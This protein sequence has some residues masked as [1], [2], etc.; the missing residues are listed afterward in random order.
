MLLIND[1][2]AIGSAVGYLL[3]GAHVYGPNFLP[4]GTLEIGSGDISP[5][6]IYGEVTGDDIAEILRLISQQANNAPD[7]TTIILGGCVIR[8]ITAQLDVMFAANPNIRKIEFRWVNFS[9]QN[10]GTLAFIL[11]KYPNLQQVS[12][13]D[14]RFKIADLKKLS[15]LLRDSR[16][17]KVSFFRSNFT[18][19]A[20]R[21]LATVAFMQRATPWLEFLVDENNKVLDLKSICMLTLAMNFSLSHSFSGNYI[22]WHSRKIKKLLEKTAAD[23]N[24][25][26]DWNKLIAQLKWSRLAVRGDQVA[27]E[28][29]SVKQRLIAP[30]FRSRKQH[31]KPQ[32]DQR[33]GTVVVS[34]ELPRELVRHMLSFLPPVIP[35]PRR[36]FLPTSDVIAKVKQAYIKPSRSW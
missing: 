29:K 21:I 32:S 34:P 14:V 13:S 31:Q 33:S 16:L 6:P 23:Y 8:D 26:R 36:D 30:F 9:A 27:I 24:Q 1:I 15:Q 17:P 12:F 5:F 20:V 3:D 4:P 11:K 7:V 28:H 10:I 19:E 25:E 18:F 35:M 22:S 2:Q